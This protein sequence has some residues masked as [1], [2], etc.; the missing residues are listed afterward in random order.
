MRLNRNVRMFLYAWAVGIL[1]LIGLVVVRYH[2][3]NTEKMVTEGDY[4]TLEP[5]DSTEDPLA[6]INDDFS[7]EEGFHT[8]L[9]IVILNVDGEIEDYKS[10]TEEG[11]ELVIE[12][13][14]P[15]T[16]GQ[17]EV[18][19][20]DDG[21]SS[22]AD[23]P[24]Y[25]TSIQIKKRG[26]TSIA[27]D[28]SQ[29]LI[30]TTLDDGSD[31]EESI[32]GMGEGDSWVLN[33]SM[34]DKSMIR[35]Y[36]AYTVASEIGGNAMAPDCRYCEVFM[37]SEDGYEYQGLYL[38]TE[39]ISRG[40]DRVDI[41]KYNDKNIYSSYIVRRDRYTSYD[42]MLDT[43][44][45]LNGYTE[46]WIGVKYPSSNK[47]SARTQEFIASDFS[48]IEKIIYSDKESEF[49]RYRKYIDMDSF[50]DYFLINEFFGNYDA[51]EHSTYMYKNPGETLKI[52]PVW[53]F[54]QAMNNY[55]ADEME[56]DTLAFQTKAF[57]D[58][59]ILDSS[60]IDALKS[61]YSVLQ[62][63]SL[64]EEH[65]YELIDETTAYIES[66][67]IREWNRWKADYEDGSFESLSN[68]YLEDY[69]VDGVTISRF[70]T[71]YEQEIYNIKNYIHKHSL[72]IQSSLSEFYDTTIYRT[73]IKSTNQL[74]LLI[75]LLLLLVP[76]FMINRKG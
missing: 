26:H 49:R 62:N 47:I 5:D 70:N 15:Y 21:E 10:F 33:G 9:P 39:T 69:E 71:D 67:R 18:I 44:G 27:Y 2:L 74:F 59:L 46:Q 14:E 20:S 16:S 30:K 22:L 40:E 3:N 48:N 36:L 35:N 6:Y 51:G 12:G 23:T 65:I 25:T 52:G 1:L 17:M 72:A 42:V 61:R 13:V 75:V 56:T 55:Y 11:D 34:A 64:S 73:D 7:V 8:N 50:V 38:L 63:K 41:E 43:Y 60:F 58:R 24:Q 76:A 28:K 4:E 37:E 31:R 66:A 32:L 57:Y 53:D 29:Y 45:R 54:D 19:Y 68:Y